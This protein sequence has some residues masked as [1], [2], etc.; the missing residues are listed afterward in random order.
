MAAEPE[1]QQEKKYSVS[2][3]WRGGGV[4]PHSIEFMALPSLGVCLL[5][6]YNKKDKKDES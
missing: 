4:T 1:G 3:I 5:M 6:W 2:I